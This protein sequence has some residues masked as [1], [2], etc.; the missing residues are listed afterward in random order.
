MAVRR[1]LAEAEW[2]D[3]IRE[4]VAA[5]ESLRAVA[6]AAGIT[7]VRVLQIVRNDPP[8]HD[9]AYLRAHRA[10]DK[11]R[12]KPK[13]CSVCGATDPE[14]VYEWA[15]LTGNYDDVSDYAR[16][17]RKCHRAYDRERRHG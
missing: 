9:A 6:G 7:H 2:R 11:A 8:Q 13:E 10:V 3:R 15:N 4:A 17:C 5:G 14:K 16:M 1:T 12:G